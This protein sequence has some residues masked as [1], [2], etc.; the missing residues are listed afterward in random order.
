MMRADTCRLPVSGDV[1]DRL[2]AVFVCRLLAVGCQRTG[3][4]CYLVTAMV[5]LQSGDFE[6]IQKLYVNLL[7]LYTVLGLIMS[8][9]DL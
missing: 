1:L 6:L 8:S 5:L 3:S 4:C 9:S 7:F 2:C